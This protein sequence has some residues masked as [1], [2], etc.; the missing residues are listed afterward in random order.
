M[1]CKNPHCKG[2]KEFELTDQEKRLLGDFDVELD[3]I[4]FCPQCREL[5]RLAMRNERVL[6]KRNCN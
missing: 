6:F 1:S 5:R 2:F 3:H 4:E